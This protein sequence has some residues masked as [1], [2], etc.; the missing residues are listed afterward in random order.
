M[1]IL[2]AGCFWIYSV[3]FGRL[4]LLALSNTEAFLS[5]H[6]YEAKCEKNTF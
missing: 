2:Y 3:D 1:E 4:T 6:I 5:F